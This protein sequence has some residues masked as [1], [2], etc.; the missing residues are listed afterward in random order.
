MN[1]PLLKALGITAEAEL[2]EEIRDAMADEAENFL[3][4]G[5]SLTLGEWALLSAST[6]EALTEGGRRL[7]VARALRIGLAAAGQVA[8]VLSEVDGG[9]QQRRAAIDL[10]LARV[11]ARRKG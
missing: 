5:G 3:L 6:R 2:S 10:A 1:D 8:D 11:A 9:E 7:E 4:A